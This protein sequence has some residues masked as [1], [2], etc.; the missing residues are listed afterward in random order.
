MWCHLLGTWL[1]SGCHRNVVLFFI[2]VLGHGHCLII[3]T[4]KEKNMR[5]ENEDSLLSSDLRGHYR[6]RE[7]EDQWAAA[8]L[9]G[10]P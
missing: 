6:Q 3:A 8:V 4:W 10:G 9:R 1:R 7:A 2:L 5:M